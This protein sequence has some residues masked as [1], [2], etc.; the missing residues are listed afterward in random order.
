M[1]NSTVNQLIHEFESALSEILPNLHQLL[2]QYQILETLEIALF[3]LAAK[4]SITGGGCMCGRIYQNP[5]QC[6]PFTPL[7]LGLDSETAQQFCTE[8]DSIL[9]TILHRLSQAVQQ[10][11]ES[12][13]VHIFI[14]PATVSNRHMFCRFVDGVLVCSDQPQ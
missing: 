7:G 8:V 14:D 13:E 1:V 10:M 11:D 5:C 9:F 3:A 4:V 12:F 6:R 2:Q